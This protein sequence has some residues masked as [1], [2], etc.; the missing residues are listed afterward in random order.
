VHI[1][2]SIVFDNSAIFPEFI[3]RVLVVLHAKTR[4]YVLKSFKNINVSI[5]PQAPHTTLRQQ[6]ASLKIF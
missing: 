4:F 2:R 1:F 5:T 6:P 3:Y